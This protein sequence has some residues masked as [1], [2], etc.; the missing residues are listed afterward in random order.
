MKFSV[1]IPAYNAHETIG[2][3]IESVVSATRPATIEL[4]VFV[5]DDGSQDGAALRM[6]VS[7]YPEVQLITQSPN[8]GKCAAVNLGVSYSK[9]DVV[10][11]LDADDIFVPEWPEVL[12]DCLQGW[13]KESP[14]CFSACKTQDGDTTVS[15]PNYTGNFTYE[16][17]LKEHRTGEYLPIFRGDA[18]RDKGGYFDS[19]M[20][21][22]CELYTYLD[23]ARSAPLWISSKILRIYKIDQGS[24]LTASYHKPEKAKQLAQ[25]YDLVFEEFGDDYSQIAPIFYSKRKLRQAV[26]ASMANER[27]AL[28]I[29]RDGARLAIP[30][31]SIASLLLILFG[32]KN[33]MKVVSIAKKLGLIRRFG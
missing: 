11:I 30:I 1:I 13:P 28:S 24:S 31:E 25:C 8:R 9:G 2:A 29:W 15:Y 5:V 23:Y 12:Q 14:I 20:S 22:P 26:F 21:V 19:K 16:D 27:R 4:E 33:T 18:V 3:T 32:G 6:V 17:I 7:A 10:T